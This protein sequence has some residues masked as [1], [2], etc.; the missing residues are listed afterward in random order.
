[1]NLF[2]V[3][4]LTFATLAA[5]LCAQTPVVVRCTPTDG[6]A[7]GCYYC[8]GY[9]TVI[10]WNGAKMHC[11]VSSINLVAYHN[12]DVRIEGI[13]NGTVVEVTSIAADIESFSIGGNGVIG[14]RMDFDTVAPIG[15]LA[16]NFLSLGFGFLVPF[17][18]L[19][20]QLDPTTATVLGGGAVGGDGSFKTRI[21][22]P[23]DA[24][25]IGLRVYGQG[26][27][28]PPVGAPYT[29]NLDTKVID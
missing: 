26:Y 5:P 8:P 27:V 22:L 11:S 19:A 10:K 12:L 23:D 20:L 9:E 2:A 6:S 7:A 24:S 25:L 13:W 4:T 14:G 15:S 21:D 28:V 29:T 1:M 16:A 3:A 18:D 17:D